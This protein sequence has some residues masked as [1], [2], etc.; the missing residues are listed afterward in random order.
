M[1]SKRIAILALKYT[2]ILTSLMMF[3]H[4]VLCLMGHEYK[5]AEL[6]TS[7]TLVPATILLWVSHALG[8]CWLHKSFIGYTLYVSM[9]MECYNNGLLQH[10]VTEHRIL[11]LVYG[12]ILFSLLIWKKKDFVNHCCKYESDN[13]LS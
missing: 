7:I 13:N 1:N 5:L 11:E 2:P 10:T 3:G 12:I 6:L 9:C 8:F 4:V